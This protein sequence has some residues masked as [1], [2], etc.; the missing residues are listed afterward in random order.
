LAPLWKSEGAPVGTL[1]DSRWESLVEWMKAQDLL[2][3]SL[4]AADAYDSSFSK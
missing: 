3:D 4:V 2:D 1:D